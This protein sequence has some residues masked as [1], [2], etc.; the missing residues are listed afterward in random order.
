MPV[1]VVGPTHAILWFVRVGVLHGHI[2]VAVVELLLELSGRLC[3]D[4][5]L[6]RGRCVL[7]LGLGGHAGIA[8]WLLRR[9]H[10]V[11]WCVS[12]A[13]SLG[14]FLGGIG[15]PLLVHGGEGVRVRQV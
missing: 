8:L 15:G 11:L 12:L 2:A 7:V 3:T 5:V 4:S 9:G 1:L 13:G 10:G 14:R 6:A